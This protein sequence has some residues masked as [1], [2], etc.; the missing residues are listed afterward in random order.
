MTCNG[1]FAKCNQSI[2]STSDVMD[3]LAKVSLFCLLQHWF[4]SNFCLVLIGA[5]LLIHTS[6]VE[7]VDHLK[8]SATSHTQTCVPSEGAFIPTLVFSLAK[9]FIEMT[10][11]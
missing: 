10:T 2:V 7:L 1:C 8:R 5:C 3:K 9:N 4:N 6:T 11:K